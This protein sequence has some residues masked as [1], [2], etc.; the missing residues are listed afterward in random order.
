[1]KSLYWKQ[2]FLLIEAMNHNLVYFDSGRTLKTAA[3]KGGGTAFPAAMYN[4]E[5][6]SPVFKSFEIKLLGK[7]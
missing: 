1:M 7:P 6:D 4:L 2:Y 3:T 5:S